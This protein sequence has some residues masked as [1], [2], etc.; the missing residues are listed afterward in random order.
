MTEETT[1]L[2][3][4]NEI[5]ETAYERLGLN[6]TDS[7]KFNFATISKT[8]SGIDYIEYWLLI[9][10]Y[11]DES[12]E[13]FVKMDATATSFG[14]Q[15][16]A[17]GTYPGEQALGYNNN[18]GINIWRNPRKSEVYKDTTNYDYTDFDENNY[19]G[20]ERR[21][22]NA[23]IEFGIGTGWINNIMTDSYGGVTLGGVGIEVDG[24]NIFPYSR[25]T[26]SK[27]NDGTNNYY[28]LGILENAYHPSGN[29]WDCDN[30][31][32]Y[33]WFFGFKYPEKT[34]AK[35]G[36]NGKFIVMYN[37]MHSINPSSSGY[38]IEDM[39]ISD[40]KV[41]LEV[42]K[43][44]TKAIVDG[45]LTV[46]GAG[47]GGGVVVDEITDGEMHAVTSN[48]V[49]HGMEL[50]QDAADAF[51]GDYDDLTNKPTIPEEVS[52]LSDGSDVLMKSSTS[53]LVKNDGTIDT[54]QYISQHQDISG[55]LD[56]AQTSNKGKN[57]VVDNSTGNI[58]F[59]D[60]PT[61]PT[62]ISDLTNDSDFIE[63][64]STSGL[65]KNDGTIDTNTYLTSA[66]LSNYVQKSNT[67]GLLK[68][69]GTVDTNSYLTQHQSLE[70]TVVTLTKQSTAESGY[71]ATYVLY[72]GG[73]AIS[74]KINIPKDFLVKSASVKTCTT[75]NVPVQGYV[76]GDKYLDF[77]VN[78]VDG[79][80]TPQHI[81]LNV[82]ELTD[83]YNADNVTLELSSGNVFSIKDGGVTYAKINSNAIGAGAN[84][85]AAGNH[86]HSTYLEKSQT[87]Y[88]G[89][90]VVV[91]ST[92]GEITFE[93]K[94]TIPTKVSD[95]TNDSGFISDV[96]GKL[97]ISQTSYK[98][99]NVVVDGT[100][101]NI[102]FEN[103]PT[104]P[105]AGSSTPSA[106]VSGGAVGSSSNFA[107]ADHQHPLSSAYATAGHNHNLTDVNNTATV[108]VTITYTDDSTETVKLVKYTG[109]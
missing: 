37:D 91:D 76:V 108:T 95:L 31:T 97:D 92:S 65:V 30:N 69:D 104:I 86:T 105:T 68:N 103:K 12:L 78:T 61:I 16:Q 52:D 34:G 5:K 98:G 35:D 82:K 24:N 23:W 79:D 39:N 84:Q 14:I 63:K 15:M 27:Y 93:N 1:L 60:K 3:F 28:L 62:K 66:N 99:K 40:W 9:N 17:K 26:S 48:A 7:D 59:E 89:K 100:T 20:A 38:T 80:E 55:K 75:D 50:K 45:V 44:G 90:N 47:G 83:V 70:G 54:T 32:K 41:I 22:D 19:I 64:S 53:G 96:S 94:P 8:E 4:P 81:Y 46:L 49:Y 56:I 25:L 33:A 58:T 71:A 102:T 36:E 18:T 73:T 72:Q 13:R 107:K 85:I 109:N 29:D 11:Y 2:N 57:V 67:A 106:D 10:A 51:S 77:V 6:E 88:K 101:G 74:P 43:T 42:S 21:S 87:S